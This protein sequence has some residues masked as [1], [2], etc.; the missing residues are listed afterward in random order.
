MARELILLLDKKESKFTLSKIQRK[1]IYGYKKRIA[2]DEKNKECE[3]AYVEEESG[4]MFKNS[5]TSSCHIDHKNNYLERNLIEAVDVNGKKVTKQDSTLGK[6]CKLNKWDEQSALNLRVNS[7]YQLD[8][9]KLDAKLQS[10]LESGNIFYFQ[11][12]YFSDFKLEDAALVKSKEGYFALIGR[13]CEAHW[14]GED[15]SVPETMM[16]EFDDTD[17]DFEMM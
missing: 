5:D 10:Q 16:A 9:V 7:V 12:N 15:S 6:P 2:M 8:P 1:N 17:L 4:I 14:I 3:R 11:F 13:K